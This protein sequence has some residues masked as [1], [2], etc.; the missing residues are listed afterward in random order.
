[1]AEKKIG[2]ALNTSEWTQVNKHNA[3]E[4]GFKSSFQD[5]HLYFKINDTTLY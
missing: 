4:L 2:I 5:K 3:K 1:M